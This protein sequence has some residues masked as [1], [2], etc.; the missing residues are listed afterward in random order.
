MK[1]KPISNKQS[2][3]VSHSDKTVYLFEKGMTSEEQAR[4]VTDVSYQR[5]G[6]GTACVGQESY[7]VIHVASKPH[8]TNL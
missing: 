5:I 1:K 8:Q 7:R 2:Q 4:G 6:V 3:L